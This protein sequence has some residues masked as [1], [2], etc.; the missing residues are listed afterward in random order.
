MTVHKLVPLIALGLNLLLLGSALAAD[1][2]GSRNIVF[3]YL[4]A[5]LALWN[6]GVFG[7]RWA[8][9]ADTALV[10]QRI[11]HVGVIPI[12]VLFYHYVLVFLE[13]PRRRLLAIGYGLGAVFLALSATPAFIGGVRE[14]LWGFVPAAG[15][16][17]ALF[18]VFFQSYLVV[19]LIHLVG[20]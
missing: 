3:A 2:R 13:Q 12:P 15:P 7:L 16:L 8:T 11:L 9:E 1:R 10:W 18:F 14:T 20:A 4:A 6:L 5:C 19:G 17:Y